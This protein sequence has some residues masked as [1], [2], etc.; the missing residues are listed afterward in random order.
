MKLT[1][2]Q[3]YFSVI[4]QKEEVN[5]NTEEILEILLR[6]HTTKV[7]ANKKLK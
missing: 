1:S 7:E 2:M 5:N 4:K 3:I 6:R